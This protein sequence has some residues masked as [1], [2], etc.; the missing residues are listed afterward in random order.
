MVADASRAHVGRAVRK[1]N[2]IGLQREL[3]AWE[4]YRVSVAQQQINR[5]R[6][7]DGPYYSRE[8]VIVSLSDMI[9]LFGRDMVM[10]WRD[11]FY[12][13]VLQVVCSFG[14]QIDK[15]KYEC[16][17]WRRKLFCEDN[18]HFTFVFTWPNGLPCRGQDHADQIVRAII[19]VRT[20]IMNAQGNTIPI[21]RNCDEDSRQL[22]A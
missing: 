22:T 15:E 3:E 9:P 5:Q 8:R 16:P 4:G 13:T 19:K 17:P 14:G 1:Q 20:D 11:N 6:D 7:P 18:L 21:S 2:E 12:R 10:A